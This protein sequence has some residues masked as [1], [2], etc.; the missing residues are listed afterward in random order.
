MHRYVH[1]STTLGKN[2]DQN[3]TCSRYHQTK[4]CKITSLMYL[5]EQ[6]FDPT[7]WALQYFRNVI[8]STF[9]EASKLVHSPAWSITMHHPQYRWHAGG[10]FR[11]V[12]LLCLCDFEQVFIGGV[13]LVTIFPR[14][15][16]RTTCADAD[17]E[18]NILVCNVR[19]FVSRNL[20]SHL[21]LTID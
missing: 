4:Q 19:C 8:S 17:P 12:W 16:F 6:N 18:R 20:L 14:E 5:V 15:H 13:T 3:K 2:L 10:I 21:R 9:F 7:L 11:S 1:P